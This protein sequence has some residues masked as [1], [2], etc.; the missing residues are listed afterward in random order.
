MNF[1]FEISFTILK[2]SCFAVDFYHFNYFQHLFCILFFDLIQ[3]FIL[4]SQIHIIR[5]FVA[6]LFH[7]NFEIENFVSCS[8]AL[9][10]M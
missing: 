2:I 10:E 7:Y 6:L 3:I 4:K 1:K 8:N 9:P 5:F